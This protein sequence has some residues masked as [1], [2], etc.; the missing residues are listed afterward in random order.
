ALPAQMA[1]AIARMARCA[2]DY[3]AHSTRTAENGPIAVTE[4]SYRNPPQRNRNLFD[5]FDTTVERS[6]R[7]GGLHCRIEPFIGI[8]AARRR[9]PAVAPGLRPWGGPG[10]RAPAL[11]SGLR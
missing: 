8:K 2:W 1:Q 6:D 10:R 7:I 4:R 9:G 11:T 3:S 5:L